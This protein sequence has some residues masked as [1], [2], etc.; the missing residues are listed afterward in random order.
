MTHMSPTPAEEHVIHVAQQFAQWR[1]SRSTP[2]GFRIP[3]ALWT[4][5]LTLAKVLPVTRVAKQLRLKPQAL[6]RRRGETGATV[7]RYA[8]NRNSSWC[9]R[10]WV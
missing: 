6:K 10:A 5:A 9:C 4:E 1:Q 8:D 2:R 7:A 3:E